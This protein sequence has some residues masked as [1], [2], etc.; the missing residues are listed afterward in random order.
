[1]TTLFQSIVSQPMLSSQFDIVRIFQRIAMMMGVK[2]V[3]EFKLQGK[4]MP[5]VQGTAVPDETVLNEAQKGNLVPL[6]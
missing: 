4:Q 5:Q 1:M 3:N 6:A 2:D